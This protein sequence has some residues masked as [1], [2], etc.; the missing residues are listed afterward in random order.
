MIIE[1]RGLPITDE[2]VEHC[3]GPASAPSDTETLDS[4]IKSRLDH[5]SE[6]RMKELS[7]EFEAKVLEISLRHVNW[8]KKK[9]AE[10]LGLSR[11]S[12]Y[13]K[14]KRHK[15]FTGKDEK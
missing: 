10:F 12:I 5:A 9:L 2:I 1:S 15:L 8:N 14:L 7:D 6:S 4:W 11:P 3:L 13:Q